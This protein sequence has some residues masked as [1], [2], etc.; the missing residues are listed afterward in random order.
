MKSYNLKFKIFAIFLILLSTF[1]F[2]LS[3]SAVADEPGGDDFV[4][5][6]HLYYDN[7][8]L[9]ADRDFEFKYDVIPEEFK[10]EI[11]VT[12]FPFK[13]EVINFKNEVAASFLFDPRKGDQEFLKGKVAVKAPYIP[14]AD[15][16]YFYDN[17]GNQL[18]T[19]F[20]GESS[21][22]DDDGICNVEKGE[23]EQTCSNDCKAIPTTDDQRPATDGEGLSG[24]AWTLIILVL[25][26]IGAGGW[27][28]WRKRKMVEHVQEDQFTNK[29]G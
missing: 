10:S 11:L 14:D 6:F 28:F 22:C 9:F 18:L 8:Q 29:L 17:Q 3:D 20:V 4:Y 26:S 23:N 13:G 16:V 24:M 2:L 12:Q 21:F 5:L 1:Y 25:A 7:G 27:Y 15:K 19:F